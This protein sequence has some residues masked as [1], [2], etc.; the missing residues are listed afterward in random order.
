MYC[1]VVLSLSPIHIEREPSVIELV[2]AN[3]TDT[4]PMNHES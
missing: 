1:V 4:Y 2:T 3:G